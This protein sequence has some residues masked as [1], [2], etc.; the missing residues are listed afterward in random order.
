MIV[1]K[2]GSLTDAAVLSCIRFVG[3]GFKVNFQSGII[4]ACQNRFHC[5]AHISFI[6][7]PVEF[8]QRIRESGF[9]RDRYPFIFRFKNT[10][11]IFQSFQEL[12][13]CL[14]RINRRNTHCQTHTQ[15]IGKLDPGGILTVQQDIKAG[16]SIRFGL[17]FYIIGKRDNSRI[18]FIKELIVDFFLRIRAILILGI[19]EI[20][21]NNRAVIICHTVHDFH[22]QHFG[23]A[24]QGRFRITGGILRLVDLWK[25]IRIHMCPHGAVPAILHIIIRVMRTSVQGFAVVHIT[26]EHIR[27]QILYQLE[28]PV[29]AFTEIIVKVN[30]LLD[31]PQTNTEAI[32]VNQQIIVRNSRLVGIKF[33]EFSC[34]A[35]R[36]QQN[37][38][39]VYINM[40][41]LHH[42][43]SC[44]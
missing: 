2:A 15:R 36:K 38:Q 44:S 7:Y 18:E 16:E 12:G 35:N 3:T 39:Q 19:R 28:R 23:N 33:T 4:V 26:G 10:K 31:N 21:I 22:F 24:E 9:R 30:A 14:I 11:F 25:D 43:P 40:F 17:L 34:T 1:R 32:V 8:S 42:L 6:P 29:L 20:L 5:S 37:P 27:V 13:A 41:F